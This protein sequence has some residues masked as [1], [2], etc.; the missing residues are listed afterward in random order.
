MNQSDLQKEFLARDCHI[1]LAE[2]EVA[3]AQE[4]VAELKYNK[5]KFM[6]DLQTE[7]NKQQEEQLKAKVEPGKDGAD[8]A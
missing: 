7:I 1:S 2:L 5:T 6:L 4:R 3:K 8:V